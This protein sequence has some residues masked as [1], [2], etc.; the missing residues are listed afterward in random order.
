[1]EFL[2]KKFDLLEEMGHMS[3]MEFPEIED[4]LS[5]R[6]PIRDYQKKCFS[7]FD[8][9][10]SNQQ[11]SKQKKPYHVLFN[12]ATGSGKTLVM[13]GLILYLYRK[14]MR[15]FLF[16]VHNNNI[17]AKTKDN[18]L[19]KGSSKYLFRDDIVIDGK[20]VYIK[21]V[22]NFDYSDDENINIHFTSVQKLHA[23]LVKT[24]KENS[25]SIED[26]QDKKIVLIGDEAHHYNANSKSQIDL[27]KSWEQLITDLHNSNE[28][29]LLL[30]FTA[31]H[32]FKSLDLT[33][34]YHDKII[35]KYDL[36]QFRIDKYSKE[37]NLIRSFQDEDGRILQALILNL[38]RQELA[39]ANGI[40]LKPVILFK[41]K[42]KIEESRQ[43]KI[44]FHRLIDEL[45]IEIVDRLRESP[46][47]VIRK[48]FEYFH[49]I[50][51]SSYEIVSRLKANFKFENC[52]SANESNKETLS[53][54]E[55]ES[56]DLLN[57]L[58][59]ENNPIRAI[60]AVQK[61]NEGWDVLN[62]FDI[63]RMYETRDGKAGKIGATTLAEAQLIGRGARYFPFAIKDDQD[64]FKRKY[65]DDLQDDLKILEDL[66]YHTKEDSRYVSELRKALEDQGSLAPNSENLIVKELKLKEEF[67][68]STF[69]QFGKVALNKKEVRNYDNVKS[70]SDLGVVAHNHIHKLSSN[71]AKSTSVFFEMERQ[72]EEEQQLSIDVKVKTIPMHIIRYAISKMPF[73]DFNNLATKFPHVNST[74]EFI[75]SDNYLSSLSITFTGTK[76][77]LSNINNEDYLQGVVG[78]LSNIERDIKAN[79]TTYQGSS[80]TTKYIHEVFIDKKIQVYKDEARADG[81]EE[82]VSNVPWYAYNANFGTEDEKAFVSLFARKFEEVNRKFGTIYLIRNERVLKIIDKLG[83]AFEPD[84]ILF[85]EQNQEDELAYQIFIE[86]KGAHLLGEENMWKEDF[87]KEMANERLLL[88]MD[89][90]KYVITGVPFYKKD[91]ENEFGLSLFQALN[92]N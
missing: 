92:L 40:N 87:L 3:D 44:K 68:K 60:F 26:F 90:K 42:S 16:F 59:N 55:I 10:S 81:Q 25:V 8:Y 76:N 73:F 58:E 18:F 36:S 38:Y 24:E 62:L 54:E 31:T 13:A 78:L 5:S 35:I 69:Y 23:D 34:K 41:A 48:A 33:R 19:N 75:E 61:L 15:N 64:R 80:F 91:F 30:E 17:L 72:Y 12:M 4:N 79:I 9:F 50:G 84:F 14:G 28:E 37:I 11:I 20:R 63:V 53:I 47:M 82:L 86:P 74:T 66:Y 32:D 6:F 56:D 51:L 52:L 46:L 77:R 65:D 57:T 85:C 49:S 45:S 70:F 7:R 2:Y 89:F 29:N 1:M 83:R 67:K 21:S 71:F 43:N 22:N 39:V 27:F 88:N